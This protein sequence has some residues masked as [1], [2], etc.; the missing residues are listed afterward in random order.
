[1]Q[2]IAVS[3]STQVTGLAAIVTVTRSEAANDRLAV[4]GLGG[5]DTLSGGALSAL[6][7]ATLD[8]GD[9]ND[10]INGG[11]G[12]DTLLGGAGNDTVDGNQ[13]NDTAF[14][15]DG[16]RHVRL[17]PGRRQR[18]R[19]GPGRRRHAPVQRLGRRGD[20]RRVVER[21]APAVHPQRRQHRHGHGRRRGPRAS[22][23]SAAPTRSTVNDLDATDVQSVNLNLGVSG[24]GDGAVDA[25]TVNGT[26]GPDAM[27]LSGG[28]GSVVMTGDDAHVFI[29]NAEAANDTLTINTSGGADVVNASG[30]LAT[31]IDLTINGGAGNDVLI[32]SDGG[33]T[34]SGDA[35]VDYVDGGP[36][37]DSGTGET[38]VNV[39]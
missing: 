19:R 14:L 22:T 8:G 10:T 30:L 37:I 28:A 5:N 9:G 32:G 7:A 1:M 38:L 12:A 4:G 27:L 25:V 16:Q 13:G 39:P 29:T 24:A 26:V 17:G 34:I 2:A 3:T 35:D 15:G 23:R 6:L 20:L 31:S 36:G 21:R 33:D 11:N 18:H